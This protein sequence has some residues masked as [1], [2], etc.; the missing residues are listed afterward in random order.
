MGTVFPSIY[1][2]DIPGTLNTMIFATKQRPSPKTLRP[3]CWHFHRIQT[4]TH[5]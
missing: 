3:I 1:T 4:S 5:C 2:M